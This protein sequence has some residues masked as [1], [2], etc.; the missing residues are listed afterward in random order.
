[1]KGK[2]KKYSKLHKHS[3]RHA[4]NPVQ[5]GISYSIK[6]KTAVTPGTPGFHNG[7]VSRYLFFMTHPASG[8]GK[9]AFF[10]I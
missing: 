9:K 1:M 6:S 5:I 3:H 2:T 4:K 10:I 7:S 8:S